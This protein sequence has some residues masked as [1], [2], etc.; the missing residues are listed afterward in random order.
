MGKSFKAREKNNVSTLKKK[1]KCS[2][3]A[4]ITKC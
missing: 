4:I 3:Y 1:I 2:L